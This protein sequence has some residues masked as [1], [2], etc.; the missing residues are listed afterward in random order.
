VSVRNGTVGASECL[1]QTRDSKKRLEGC[2]AS[3]QVVGEGGGPVTGWTDRLVSSLRILA[4]VAFS[5][6]AWSGSHLEP[7]NFA[8]R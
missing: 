8:D 2:L 1:G 5:H 6:S 3:K 4:A 7:M